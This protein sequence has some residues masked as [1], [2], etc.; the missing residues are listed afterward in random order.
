MV[1]DDL[2]KTLYIFAGKRN[3][4]DFLADMHAYDIKTGTSTELFNNFKAAGG[5]EASSTQRAV[6][7]PSLKEIYVFSGLTMHP[8]SDPSQDSSTLK[9]K[10]T[11][12]WVYRYHTR[13]GEWMQVL[14]MPN[15]SASERPKPRFGHQ[16]VYNPQTHQI[17]LHG[18]NGGSPGGEGDMGGR[19]DDFWRMEFKR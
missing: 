8:S 9:L 7:D 10:D 16:V 3:S 18:G 4:D 19:L 12:N 11:L 13:P 6:I 5:P 14:K 17:Y 1:L 2:T 15:A